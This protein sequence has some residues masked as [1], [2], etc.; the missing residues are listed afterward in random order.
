MDSGGEVEAKALE[1]HKID[2]VFEDRD[3]GIFD[4]IFFFRPY[5]PT[6]KQAIFF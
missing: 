3:G 1:F 6:G 5:S 4:T 2:E